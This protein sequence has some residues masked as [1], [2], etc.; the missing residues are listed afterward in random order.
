MPVRAGLATIALLLL[1]LL[2]WSV[3]SGHHVASSATTT[4]P[5]TRNATPYSLPPVLAGRHVVVTDLESGDIGL[6]G[7]TTLRTGGGP[8]GLA[9]QPGGRYL[10][11]SNVDSDR[12][13]SSISRRQVNPGGWHGD[14]GVVASAC[15]V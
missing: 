4:V 15:R 11:V 2:G 14:G 6:L 5:V 13:G 3:L 10:W 7:V 9:M 8:H 1:L 12:F